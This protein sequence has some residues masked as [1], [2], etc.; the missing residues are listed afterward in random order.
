VVHRLNGVKVKFGRDS[1]EYEMA[2][3]VRR[4]ERKRP[5]RKPIVN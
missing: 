4:S 1:S 5:Q 3:R 2:G